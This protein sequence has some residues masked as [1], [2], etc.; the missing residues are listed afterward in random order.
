MKADR[1]RNR[2]LLFSFLV[3]LAGAGMGALIVGGIT[4]SRI[5]SLLNG[6][7]RARG[8]FLFGQVDRALKLDREQESVILPRIIELLEYLTLE[9]RKFALQIH[10]VSQEKIDLIRKE[11]RPEQAEKFDIMLKTLL[12]KLGLDTGG[13]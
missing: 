6:G 7:P 8:E 2:F 11:L 13:E 1:N 5:Q 10:P 12:S 9:R 3:F 4:T